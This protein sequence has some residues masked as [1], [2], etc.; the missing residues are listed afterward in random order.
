M[1]DKVVPLDQLRNYH[2]ILVH[3][4]FDILHIGHIRM[5]EAARS[6]NL[7][8]PLI[9]TVTADRFIQKGPGRPCF[10]APTR[11]ECLEALSCVD[12][13]SVVDEPT[14]LTP[15][16]MIRPKFYVKGREYEG[17]G[18]IAKMEREA[19]LAWGGQVVYTER[20]ASSTKL[21]ERVKQDLSNL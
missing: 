5:L 18:G 2:G 17:M 4:V 21:V 8:I 3:G 11:M 6:L 13:I 9:V 7:T 15:I 19:V 20:L 12:F 10:P 1:S 14:A 16:Q